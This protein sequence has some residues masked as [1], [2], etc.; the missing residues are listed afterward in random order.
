MDPIHAQIIFKVSFLFFFSLSRFNAP[1]NRRFVKFR[2]RNKFLAIIIAG[3]TVRAFFSRLLVNGFVT[4][5]Y[6]YSRGVPLKTLIPCT[7]REPG[8][9]SPSLSFRSF[10]RV[11]FSLPPFGF[12]RVRLSTHA[13]F[14]VR[15]G[16]GKLTRSF[17][18][19]GGRGRVEREER[20]RASETR[21][22]R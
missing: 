3:I 9:C 1:F 5:A 2:E 17:R 16:S 6:S 12:C 10:N 13:Y 22:H 14:P 8:S 21:H 11:A 7:T 20:Y 15:E 4:H 19:V 18:K